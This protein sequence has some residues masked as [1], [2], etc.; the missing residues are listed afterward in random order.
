MNRQA[1]TPYEQRKI[2]FSIRVEPTHCQHCYQPVVVWDGI[3]ADAD[4]DPYTPFEDLIEHECTADD[5]DNI[6]G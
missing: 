4:Q 1:R 6:E 3:T 5:D 2:M